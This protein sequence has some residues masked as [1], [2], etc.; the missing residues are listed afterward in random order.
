MEFKES[1]TYSKDLINKSKNRISAVFSNLAFLD[2]Y[3]YP[4][5]ENNLGFLLKESNVMMF[6]V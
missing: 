2:R 5:L 1:I 6:L 3:Y 4:M